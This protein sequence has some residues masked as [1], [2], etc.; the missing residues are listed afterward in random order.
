MFKL[1]I[2]SE[3]QKILIII[4]LLFVSILLIFKLINNNYKVN[5][6]EFNEPEG[7]RNP[8]TEDY[9]NIDNL[10][11]LI[12]FGV[13]ERAVLSLKRLFYDYQKFK[14]VYIIDT[15]SLKRELTEKQANNPKYVTG[16]GV[17]KFNVKSE[18][19]N[20]YY[21]KIVNIDN[22]DF[23]FVIYSDENFTNKIYN[24]VSSDSELGD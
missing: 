21:C 24:Y 15:N 10:D 23:E 7:F 3:N 1:N 11:K 6:P 17:F 2:K 22:Y 13:P 19:N 9:P 16:G 5:N 14:T 20:M 12:N 18:N 4:V 8:G